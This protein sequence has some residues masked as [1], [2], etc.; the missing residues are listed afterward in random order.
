MTSLP[1]KNS[2]NE[3]STPAKSP[4]DAWTKPFVSPIV[5]NPNFLNNTGSK[6]L[7]VPGERKIS[8]SSIGSGA[9]EFSFNT[10]TDS[11]FGSKENTPTG[12][13]VNK[14]SFNPKKVALTDN[15]GDTPVASP[16]TGNSNAVKFSFNPKRGAS[17]SKTKVSAVTKEG[18]QEFT[19]DK[20]RIKRPNISFPEPISI[21]AKTRKE[22]EKVLF[23]TRCRLYR[24]MPN[25]EAKERGK[26]EL[27]ILKDPATG[28]VR[29]LM[30]SEDLLNVYA[31]FAI[32]S[33]FV[34]NNTKHGDS[35]LSWACRDYSNTPN[36]EDMTLI[37]RFKDAETAK[38]FEITAKLST[39]S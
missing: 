1:T 30:R 13:S 6:N 14:F 26:G 31:N 4:F 25:S 11:S 2:T 38:K 34:T 18:V 23:S 37:C 36:G 35:V 19:I 33:G 22:N 29:C 17:S 5:G 24:F 21:E 27:K 16:M 20:P 8:L 9:S 39:F 32:S 12:S 15:K 28:K 7:S 10:K 3:T